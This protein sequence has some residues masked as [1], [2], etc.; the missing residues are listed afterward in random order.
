MKIC[1]HKLVKQ[2]FNRAIIFLY[3]PFLTFLFYQ[4]KSATSILKVFVGAIVQKTVGAVQHIL[5]LSAHSKRRRIRW[6][7]IYFFLYELNVHWLNVFLSCKTGVLHSPACWRMKFLFG[8]K[9]SQHRRKYFWNKQ[10]CPLI[11]ALVLFE[12]V[13]F[14]SFFS[15]FFTYSLLHVRL[16]TWEIFGS[17]Q[18]FI[19]YITPNLRQF[20]RV[21]WFIQV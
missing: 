16:K 2:V 4:G 5:Y 13:L 12:F 7:F 18:W 6:P 9:G 21:T 1:T 3:C 19:N 15:F 14:S 17:N 11:F 8:F 10:I 20:F